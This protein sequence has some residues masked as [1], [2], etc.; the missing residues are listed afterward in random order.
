MQWGTSGAWTT[1]I[2]TWV[3]IPESTVEGKNQF[4]RA[5]SWLPQVIIMVHHGQC[6]CSWY[7]D[8]DLSISVPHSSHL[9]YF[10]SVSLWVQLPHTQV[11]PWIARFLFLDLPVS[12]SM[13]VPFCGFSCPTLCCL[14][15]FDT[16]CTL[17]YWKH[18]W[19]LC[20][21]FL[22]CSMCSS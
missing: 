11:R 6:R 9:S 17:S 12:S 13:N 8:K 18:K 20:F 10:G 14:S 7:L 19:L 16:N 1:V 21:L 22:L 3:P 4:P 15:D 2:R 5:G